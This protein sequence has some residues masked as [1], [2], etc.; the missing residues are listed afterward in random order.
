MWIIPPTFL[1]RG[2]NP[3]DSP[4][5]GRAENS[6]SMAVAYCGGIGR[7]RGW[8]G[9]NKNGKTTSSCPSPSS[10]G[11]AGVLG[12]TG[13]G[14]GREP[15][16]HSWRAL[17]GIREEEARSRKQERQCTLGWAEP[18]T[19]RPSASCGRRTHRRTTRK[20]QFEIKGKQNSDNS[21]RNNHPQQEEESSSQG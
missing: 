4:A 10:W 3:L 7:P 9:C 18:R 17:E 13:H 20:M 5:I 2:R 19:Q 1:A 15:E 14:R 21:C 6:R 11:C 8:Q 16:I 12:P